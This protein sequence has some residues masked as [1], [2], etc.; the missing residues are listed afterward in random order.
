MKPAVR[1]L[2]PFAG[3]LAC[4]A[5]LVLTP[6]PRAAAQEGA[7]VSE[8]PPGGTF[9]Q[10][11]HAF[12]LLLNRRQCLPLENEQQLRDDP[13]HSLLIVLGDPAILG[14]LAGPHIRGFGNWLSEF[15][16]R[17]GALLV[18]TDQG[19]DWPLSPFGIDIKGQFVQATPATDQNLVY[20]GMPQCL[21]L[22]PQRD[23][24]ELFRKADRVATN[25]PS[26]LNLLVHPLR[27]EEAPMVLPEVARLPPRCQVVFRDG[28]W[29]QN[30]DPNER[31]LAAVGSNWGKGRFLVLADHSVFIN[32]MMIQ[33]DNTN[34]EFAYNCINWLT[35]DGRR[36]KVLFYED[37]LV[38]TNFNLPLKEPPFPSDGELLALANRMLRGVGEERILDRLLPGWLLPVLLTVAL[39]GYGFVRLTGTRHRI[40]ASAPLFAGA[41]A[42]VNP[43]ETLAEQRHQA[44]LSG[45]NFWEQARALARQFFESATGQ[46]EPESPPVVQVTGAWRDRR[47][48]RWLVA[49]L[50]QLAYGDKPMLVSREEFPQLLAQLDDVKA[51]LASGKLRFLVSG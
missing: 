27:A 41:L 22:Q 9:G 26:Y 34:L 51:A 6:V 38:R 5:S 17:G 28:T 20:R 48:L 46:V 24:L 7:P 30:L 33:S 49:R 21:L 42:R 32:D 29:F 1:P 47:S 15:V 19:V 11:S 8:L 16:T 39:L 50:W 2:P 35:E 45:G 36:N 37:G 43:E 3:L 31:L 25:K 14:T 44:L 18:A 4:L 40:D 13:E 10:G 23:R 12:R